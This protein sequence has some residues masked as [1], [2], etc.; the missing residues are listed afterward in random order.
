M[1]QHENVFTVTG[2]S[3]GM[4][5]TMY[6][7]A[8]NTEEKAT[9]VNSLSIDG[10]VYEEK[11][12]AIKGAEAFAEKLE[13][14]EFLYGFEIELENA[15]SESLVLEQFDISCPLNK[16]TLG[17][18]KTSDNKTY[19]VYM[20]RGSIPQGN[21]TYTILINLKDGTQLKGSCYLDLQAPR[22]N[23][24]SIEW[25]DAGTI[26]V[27][28]NSDE[29]GTLYYA[30]QDEVEGEGTI[31]AKDPAQIYANGTKI[32]IGYGLNYVTVKDVKAGQ[33]FCYV[34]E[35][36]KG[37]REDFYSYKQIPE[38]TEPVPDD[39]SQPQITGVTV[40]RATNGAKLK[41][42]FNQTVYGLYDNSMTQISGIDKRLAF[43]TEYSSEGELEDN[44]LT[45]T[46]MDPTISIPTGSH[47]L[48][49][50]FY[51]GETLTF[52]FTV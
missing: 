28:V 42:V 34:S 37:N 13:N 22:V 20:Q 46:V 19:R 3:Q 52:D 36:A 31:T 49:I 24:R 30:I 40:L 1:K 50:V 16:T 33:W 47:T 32:S 27:V 14:G 5:Y 17:D 48:T 18:V 9:L 26:E 11:T 41:V 44:V 39:T 15:T 7:V 51:D 25:K 43:S 6:Y 21:N 45:L 2:L 29:A 4:S 12:T 10:E 8:V 35:D 38:Y 23:A